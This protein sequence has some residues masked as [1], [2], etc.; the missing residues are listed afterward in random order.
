M[1][2]VQKVT[3]ITTAPDRSGKIVTA[4]ML[5]MRCSL[6][7]ISGSDTASGSTVKPLLKDTAREINIPS[8]Q[9]SSCNGGGVIV[10]IVE[11]GCD[12]T[13]SNF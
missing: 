6:S 12:F 3:E 4:H 2:V 13:Y 8:P 11:H 7:I 1:T 9:E 10:G 5:P